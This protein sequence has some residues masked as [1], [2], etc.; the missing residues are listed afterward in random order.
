[1]N[2]VKG[3]I[4]FYTDWT[5]H[6][7][8]HTSNMLLC[9][10]QKGMWVFWWFFKHSANEHLVLRFNDNIISVGNRPICG[11]KS[12]QVIFII[13]LCVLNWLISITGCLL[14][15]LH[16]YITI[17]LFDLQLC[18]N[19]WNGIVRILASQFV[20]TAIWPNIADIDGTKRIILCGAERTNRHKETS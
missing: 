15:I 14:C 12:N 8:W 3:V 10:E 4:S 19:G 5:N 2:Y 16:T 20:M 11:L 18:L 6:L 7:F 17:F 9:V 13:G 1:M